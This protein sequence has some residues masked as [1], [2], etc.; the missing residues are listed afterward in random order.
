[1]VVCGT[2]RPLIVMPTFGSAFLFSRTDATSY[3][4][5]ATY[6]ASG[7][8]DDTGGEGTFCAAMLSANAAATTV[9]GEIRSIGVTSLQI[10]S[11]MKYRLCGAFKLD[12][13]YVSI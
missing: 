5:V 8:E 12:I 9:A 6:G 2:N 10:L 4:I 13:K 3:V 11:I 7:D 1:M